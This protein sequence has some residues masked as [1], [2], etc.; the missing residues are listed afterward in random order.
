MSSYPLRL[1]LC[2]TCFVLVLEMNLEGRGF[3]ATA[4]GSFVC[5]G[6]DYSLQLR[7]SDAV[8]RGGGRIS[9]LAAGRPQ[10]EELLPGTFN[11]FMG[12][13]PAYW[14]T[15]VRR[16]GR[17]R[18]RNVAP[19]TD[20]VFYQ[21]PRGELEYD[22]IVSPGSD[23]TRIRLRF[24]GAIQQLPP[25]A[26]QGK[27][28]VTARFHPAADGAMEFEIGDYDRTRPLVIDP[29]I[30]FSTYLGSSKTG[31]LIPVGD[32]AQAVA[33]DALGNI[34]VTG[35]TTGADFPLKP[36]TQPVFGG[37][38]NS[39]F[40]LFGDAFV[41]KFD[42]NGNLVFSTL[43]GG[44][45]NELAKAI[46]LDPLGNITITG[47]TTSTNLPLVNPAQAKYRS[48]FG[49]GENG[50][51]AKFS[52]SGNG[53]T[54]STYLGGSMIDVP[55]ALAVDANGTAYIAGT[56][57][58]PDFPTTP[59]VLE[60]II[61]SNQSGAGFVT[62]LSTG[63]QMV[64][65]TF[66][67]DGALN[68]IAVDAQGNAYIA[69]TDVV[70]E[71]NPS[72][73]GFVFSMPPAGGS[74]PTFAYGIAVDTAG[75]IYVG[76]TTSAPDFPY[77]VSLLFGSSTLKK[78]F[79]TKMGPRGRPAA[80]S[81]VMAPFSSSLLDLSAMR[82]DAEGAVYLAGSMP[83]GL[84]FL[85]KASHGGYDAFV[86]KLDNDGTN[87]SMSAMVGGS[88][89]DA[90]YGLAVDLNGAAILVGSTGSADFPTF[91]AFQN[92]L[93]SA[94]N[95]FVTK[96]LP[97]RLSQATVAFTYDGRAANA[98]QA[99]QVLNTTAAVGA[100]DPDGGSPWLTAV[101]AG[102]SVQVSVN[103]AAAD[104]LP[105][106]TYNGTLRITM[107]DGDTLVARGS[108]VIQRVVPTVTAGGIVNA[109]SFAA[110]PLA[111]GSLFSIIGS[112]L[113]NTIASGAFL[114][115]LSGASVTIGGIRAPLSYASPAQINGQVPYEL[116]PGNAVLALHV[117]NVGDTRSTVSITDVSPALFQLSPGRAVAQNQDYSINAA[118]TPAKP[119]TYI[120][121]YLTG[122]GALDHPV[123]TGVAAPLDPLSRALGEVTATIG[124]VPATVAFCGLA[125][126]FVGLAQA[127]VLVPGLPPGDYP[128]VITIGTANS[129]PGA[130]SIGN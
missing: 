62:K 111:P 29:V 21:S 92:T 68:A 69:G 19:G 10:P 95:A 33:T 36:A 54:Y 107:T 124:G 93:R 9:W 90:G 98:P 120:V 24:D 30:V 76:G 49:F 58:S 44:T 123:P 61:P 91:N 4:S 16:Y 125:P 113:A 35:M 59:G 82:V 43:Y 83:P 56:T 34:Y 32:H 106:G 65:S 48:T 42:P 81:T 27:R 60:Q 39:G 22:L 108:L 84:P 103:R 114:P 50:F 70:A 80:Y 117:D 127:N 1:L 109:A 57:L 105:D 45:G 118:G 5:S 77:T 97:M 6:A 25:Y 17:V 129:V 38:Q 110:G 116:A 74:G 52:A 104:N 115:A 13:D 46:A 26:Y 63:G 73:T 12:N 88:G 119:G 130:I 87:I 15:D 37:G 53:L 75:N 78:M 89:N 41:S 100:A 51:V 99:L 67:S 14:R 66:A 86:V 94:E 96:L 20:L 121:V 71:L 40:G 64:Y 7:R 31:G 18:Y 2:A 101:I 79:V 112:R 28:A 8:L 126:G 102:A 47:V 55:N 11:Y 122:Q 128:L 85:S 3:E 72:G 23:P